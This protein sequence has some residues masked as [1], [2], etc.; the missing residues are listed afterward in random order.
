MITKIKTSVSISQSLLEELTPFNKDSNISQFIEQALTYYLAE[1]K[2]QVRRER[3]RELLN[4]N[5]VQFNKEA[6]EN[7]EFQDMP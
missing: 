1:L 7:L 4:A 5:A 2:R 3:D 6:E